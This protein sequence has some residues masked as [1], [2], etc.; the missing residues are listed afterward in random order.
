MSL[1]FDN[2]THTYETGIVSVEFTVPV[3]WKFYV[4]KHSEGYF[5]VPVMAVI[6][7]PP[8]LFLKKIIIFVFAW[9][10]RR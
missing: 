4:A 9:R 6:S 1:D 10:L 7:P 2:N 8:W 5:A 3:I